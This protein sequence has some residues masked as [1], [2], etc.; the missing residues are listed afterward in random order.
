MIAK[1]SYTGLCE[2]CLIYHNLTN[3]LMMPAH[4]VHRVR[5]CLCGAKAS[6]EAKLLVGMAKRK[7]SYWLCGECYVAE[8]G[9][10]A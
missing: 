1:F 2:P 10:G 5:W 9:K 3:G 6:H 4:L 8:F 7:E